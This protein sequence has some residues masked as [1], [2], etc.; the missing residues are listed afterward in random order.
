MRNA[1]VLGFT[2]GEGQGCAQEGPLTQ[3]SSPLL[4][5]PFP[6]SGPATRPAPQWGLRGGG[7]KRP[8]PRPSPSRSW[9]PPSA[10]TPQPN[11][12]A[13]NANRCAL[14]ACRPGSS[15]AASTGAGAGTRATTGQ[16]PRMPVASSSSSRSRAASQPCPRGVGPS[17]PM[18]GD[19]DPS[20]TRP[21]PH[22]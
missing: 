3:Q 13:P 10:H 22:P 20:L 2:P 8:W 9:S 5:A 1:P 6:G 7:E 21:D 19:A 4:P 18:T 11:A 17:C 16:D 12:P 14:P 15:V